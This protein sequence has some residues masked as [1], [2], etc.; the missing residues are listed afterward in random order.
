[1]QSWGST[2]P[3][4]VKKPTSHTRE[5]RLPLPGR[6]GCLWLTIVDL[7]RTVVR[8]LLERVGASISEAADGQ[9]AVDLFSRQEF[10]VV[11]M[12]IIMPVMDRV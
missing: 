8:L 5:K 10:D 1:M 3:T 9:P 7:N 12:D 6:F 4:G 11:I 2:S